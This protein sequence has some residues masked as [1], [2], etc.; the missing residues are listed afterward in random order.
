MSMFTYEIYSILRKK[1]AMLLI[2][3]YT[4]GKGAILHG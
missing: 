3:T 2:I 4:L 1:R